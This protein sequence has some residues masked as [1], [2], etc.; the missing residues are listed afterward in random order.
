MN[1]ERCQGNPA[2][3]H[4]TE[5]KDNKKRVI[6]LCQKCA[7]EMQTGGFGFLPQLNLHNFL[8]G[9]FSDSKTA[10]TSLNATGSKCPTCGLMEGQF[11]A[12]GLLGCGDCYNHFGDSLNPI[13]RRIHG[14]TKHIGKVPARS[15]SRIKLSREIERLKTKLQESVDREEFEDAAKFRDEIK[16]FEKILDKGED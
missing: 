10:F 5:I 12:T 2:V 7:V 6:N 15:G 4:I 1:C 14:T 13:Y 16:D 3:V 8:A 9:L 11:I